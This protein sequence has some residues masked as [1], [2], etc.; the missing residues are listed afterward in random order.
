MS[1]LLIRIMLGVIFMV[2]GFSKLKDPISWEKFMA[3]FGLPKIMANAIALIEFLG[4][5]FILLGVFTKISSIAMIIFMLFAI[6]L[7]HKDKG[8]LAQK[9]GY[10]YQ[11]LIIVC[12]VVVALNGGGLYR[13]Y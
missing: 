9:G 4:G 1:L 12:C 3:T 2:H 5:L 8:F 7:V 6:F 13:V 10:E 11:L